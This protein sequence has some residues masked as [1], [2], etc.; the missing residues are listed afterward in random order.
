MVIA[1]RC[2]CTVALSKYRFAKCTDTETAPDMGHNAWRI[3]QKTSNKKKYLFWRNTTNRNKTQKYEKEENRST[4]VRTNGEQGKQESREW[5]HNNKD[6]KK[7][8]WDRKGKERKVNCLLQM[9]QTSVGDQRRA[10]V[11][12]GCKNFVKFYGPR[13]KALHCLL[14]VK[15]PATCSLDP[16]RRS[17]FFNTRVCRYETKITQRLSFGPF[18][19]IIALA[20]AK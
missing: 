20:N 4:K 8:K 3:T 2:S 17:Y 10:S 13:N 14:P 12:A 9:Q 11:V 15:H 1:L 6:E 5:E 7:R 16:I 19:G 18:K